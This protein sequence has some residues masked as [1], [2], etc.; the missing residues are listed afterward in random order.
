MKPTVVTPELIAA[1]RAKLSEEASASLDDHDCGR[2]LVARSFDLTKSSEMATNWHAWYNQPLVR[3]N[4]APKDI[5]SINGGLDLEEDVYRQH[6]PHSNV[7]NDKKGNPI[8][9]QYL[10]YKRRAQ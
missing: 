7:G 1:F 5:L 2:F 8:C 4:V 10:K 3:V 6:M 9:K